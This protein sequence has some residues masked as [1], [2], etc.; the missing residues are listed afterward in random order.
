MLDVRAALTLRAG[1]D[2]GGQDGC[3]DR[4][5]DVRKLHQTGP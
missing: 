3:S 1:P 2:L 5:G 4:T